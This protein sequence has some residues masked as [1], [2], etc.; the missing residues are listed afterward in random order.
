MAAAGLP[1]WYARPALAF[2]RET[3]LNRTKKTGPNDRIQIGVIGSGDRFKGGLFYDVKRHKPFVIVACCDVDKEHVNQVAD[4]AQ[5]Q[6]K[7]EVARIIDFRELLGA[8]RP[9]GGTITQ[10][11]AGKRPLAA[12]AARRRSSGGIKSLC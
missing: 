5:K 2:D 9:F 4:Q 3:A 10:I 12:A 6:Y 8:I 7:N 1:L 11:F